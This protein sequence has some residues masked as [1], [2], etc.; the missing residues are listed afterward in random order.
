MISE[1]VIYREVLKFFGTDNQ[2][3]QAV[4]ELN[5]LAAAIMKFRRKRE[6]AADDLANVLEEMADVDIMLNQLKLIFKG[7]MQEYYEQKQ[8]KLNRLQKRLK[9]GGKC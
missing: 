7:E 2:L 4:E 9:E 3:Q 8:Y 5:E 1:E 6:S